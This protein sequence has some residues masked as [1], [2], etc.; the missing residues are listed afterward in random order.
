MRLPII[1][2]VFLKELRELLRDRRS[3]AVMFGIPLVLYPVLTI[4][5][6]SLGQSRV[7][8]L[9]EQR[10]RV[11]VVNPNGAPELIRRLNLKE[12]GL[13]ILERPTTGLTATTGPTTA[14]IDRP[15]VT[16]AV[17][18]M[19]EIPL[20][21]EPDVIAGKD[22]ALT[23]R[24]DRSRTE[25]DFAQ[26]KLNA[27][28]N[29]YEEW[30]I[31]QR[32]SRYN[33]PSAITKG[34]EEKVID[35]ST[36]AQ[37]MGNRLS[38]LMPL[39]ILITGML[40]ALFP[41]LAATTTERELGTLET[42][43]VTP[44]S[45]TELL[46]AKGLLVLLCGVLTGALNCLSM[47]LVLW[48]TFSLAMPGE[49]LTI[50]YSSLALAFLASVP[51]LVFFTAMVLLV[52]LLARTFREANS[53][54][55]PAM[56]LPIAS[57]ALTIADVQATPGLLVTPIANTTLVMRDILRNKFL[58]GQF[59]VA[60]ISSLVY[61]G[62]L[63]SI[64]ARLFS[65]E[66]LVNP[67]W[68]PLSMK[69]LGRGRSKQRAPRI[70]AVDEAIALFAIALLLLFYVQPSLMKLGLIPTIII[71]QVFLLFA[72]A[73]VM[74]W[75]GNWHWRDTFQLR[76]SKPAA[77]GGAVLLGIG[78]A[79]VVALVSYFQNKFWPPPETTQKFINE[80][81]VPALQ[82]HP[83]LIPI[84]V[85]VFAGVF[86]ELLFRG[87]IQTA[88]L[89][90]AR[91]ATA[92]TVTAIIFAAAHLDLHGLP[93]R[94]LLGLILGWVVYHTRSILPAVL[95]HVLYDATQLAIAAWQVHHEDPAAPARL[96]AWFWARFG[97]GALMTI[98]GYLSIRR[99]ARARDV[100][101][102]G[103]RGLEVVRAA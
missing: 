33:V 49:G 12:S 47:S 15:L 99:A 54:A 81:F 2:T 56:L 50:N 77:T 53:Y 13:E 22:V 25:A 7:T 41:A 70:P 40:G 14:A 84:I 87:P 63:L 5:L 93:L 90:K 34:I 61:A 92:I 72:P 46:L 23:L 6:A 45:R 32:L 4:A 55:T 21:F 30:V 10:Y 82:A 60:S 20:G 62:L 80:L 8:G 27:V 38:Q 16:G 35:V 28:L 102:D 94:T 29:K 89:R 75:L 36:A 101:E 52:G 31:A 65:N 19:L 100:V 11:A 3:L 26:R 24:L 74:A 86:E 1:K 57:L 73:V 96:D 78:L 64:A 95:I 69:G 17:E 18:A 85:G 67:S 71:T 91:P 98:V 59:T 9:K 51:A 44:A 83:F 76:A 79:P 88:L 68:E 48:R 43:L 97:I 42:L 103:P 66:Q 58:A 39:L 37:R